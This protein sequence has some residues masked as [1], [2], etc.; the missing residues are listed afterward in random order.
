MHNPLSKPL[1]CKATAQDF[2][3]LHN[4]SASA[5]DGFLGCDGSIGGD[6]EIEASE[7]RVGYFVCGEGYVVIFVEAGGEEV[8]ECVV[9]F[10]EGEDGR[11]GDAWVREQEVSGKVL[12]WENGVEESLRVS[13]FH[14]T[15]FSPSSRRKSSN[16]SP[17]SWSGRNWLAMF[18]C[19]FSAMMGMWVEAARLLRHMV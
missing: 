19:M 18:F 14:S 7:E 15:F 12:R 2:Q 8:A 6:A 11:V 1:G 17:A 4:F 13:S 10:V 5:D 9:F 3:I 16:L